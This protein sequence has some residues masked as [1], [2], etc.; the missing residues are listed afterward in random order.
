MLDYGA[1]YSQMHK[2]DK[3]FRGNSIKAGVTDIADL[4]RAHRPRRIIDYGCGKGRQYTEHRVHDAWGGLMPDLYDV[5][6][7]E[8]SR[9][10]VGPFDAAICTDVMEHIDEP[11]VDAVLADIFGL[12]P[13]RDDGG[14]S[15]A[16]FYICC[17][18][19]AR[20]TLPDGRNVHL[21]VK[22]PEWWHARL[23]AFDRPGLV[24]AT[25]FDGDGA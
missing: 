24:I 7:A 13:P 15:F 17:R 11:D 20:K 12:L 14:V 2:S 23:G 25:G 5:G 6:V 10:P 9:A 1:M 19:A 8:Y 16:Y 3:A 21:C 22:A 4:V 18:P